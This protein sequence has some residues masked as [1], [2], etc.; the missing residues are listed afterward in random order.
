M[1]L[2]SGKFICPKCGHKGIEKFTKW[3]SRDI[4]I[5][6]NKQKQWIIYY[7][8]RKNGNVHLVQIVITIFYVAIIMIL[9]VVV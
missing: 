6:Q 8:K 9:I 2:D 5:N 7:K 3:L 1:N 4:Y